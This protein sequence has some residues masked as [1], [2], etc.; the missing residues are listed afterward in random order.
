[1]IFG[2]SGVGDRREF[3]RTTLGRIAKEVATR[4]EQRVV[5]ERYF[6]PPGAA[7]EVTFLS[8]CTRCGTCTEVCPAHA[9]FPAPPRAGL[10]AGTPVINPATQPCVVCTDMPCAVACPTD[11]LIV[12]EHKW[13]GYSMGVLELVPETC[14][15]FHGVACGACARA[16]PLGETA[17]ALDQGGRPVLKAEGCVGCGVCVRAC[18]TSPPSLKLRVKE[19]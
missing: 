9:I 1:L 12:P 5:V 8:A 13:D 3:F 7:D 17:I 18:V 14:I 15:A 19:S 2:R 4:A 11:A 10:A 16:C 6:R